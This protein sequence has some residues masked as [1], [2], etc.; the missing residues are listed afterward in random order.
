MPQTCSKHPLINDVFVHVWDVFRGKLLKSP[1]LRGSV[2][3]NIGASLPQ[4][5][6][7]EQ[8]VGCIPP[9]PHSDADRSSFRVLKGWLTFK[10][11]FGA[12]VAHFRLA[13]I[14]KAGKKCFQIKK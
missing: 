10:S 12:K 8:S 2:N 13:F 14:A 5:L 4:S 1:I 3:R 9:F 7:P 6:C 11:A